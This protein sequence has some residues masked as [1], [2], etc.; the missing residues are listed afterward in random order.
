VKYTWPS[1]PIAQVTIRRSL[2]SGNKTQFEKQ[3]QVAVRRGGISSGVCRVSQSGT[4]WLIA[5]ASKRL[6]NGA[7]PE[8][9]GQAR[10]PMPARRMSRRLQHELRW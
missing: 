7:S 8:D 5:A 1:T 6:S 3:F 4:D 10:T 2:A 9:I